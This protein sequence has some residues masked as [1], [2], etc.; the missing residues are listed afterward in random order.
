MCIHIHTCLSDTA[1][2]QFPF[3][4]PVAELLTYERFGSGSHNRQNNLA[5]GELQQRDSN[6]T[7]NRT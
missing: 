3:N 4:T 6:P 2:T 1:L 5:A 7:T